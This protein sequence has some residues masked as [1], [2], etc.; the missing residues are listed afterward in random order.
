MAQTHVI[1]CLVTLR[2]KND[3][4]FLLMQDDMEENQHQMDKAV[5]EGTTSH[6]VDVS[7]SKNVTPE[8]TTSHPIEDII[9]VPED[10]THTVCSKQTQEVTTATMIPPPLDGTVQTIN[11]I[12]PEDTTQG[13]RTLT[14][15]TTHAITS[16]QTLDQTITSK[17]THD[18]TTLAPV[19]PDG[20][21]GWVIMIASFFC[22][23]IV[24][25]VCFR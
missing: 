1:V 9:T 6:L 21:Y 15:R 4:V 22:N 18:D 16:R 7:T 19:P 20:G 24:D 3:C 12:P 13:D 11:N 17:Q 2:K 23:V 8:D 5:P 25:G 14:E 10:T